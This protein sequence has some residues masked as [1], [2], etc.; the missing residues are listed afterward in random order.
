MLD[1]LVKLAA[2]GTSGICI[3]GIFWI[4]YLI[5]NPP[6]KPDPQRYDTLRFFMMTCIAIAI[7]SAVASIFGA[8]NDKKQIAKSLAIVL[9]SKEGYQLDHPSPEL[10]R[11]I[12]E[13]KAFV[14]Q[15]GESP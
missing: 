10:A 8:W 13:L 2:L 5:L 6:E 11:Y 14:A 7:I 12:D 1:T 4:G 15:M 3:F 9:K